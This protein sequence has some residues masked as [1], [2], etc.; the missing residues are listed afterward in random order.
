MGDDKNNERRSEMKMT[1][2]EKERAVRKRLGLTVKECA[3]AH[4]MLI[5]LGIV[6]MKMRFAK[7]RVL[8]PPLIHITRR[9]VSYLRQALGYDLVY[10]PKLDCPHVIVGGRMRQWVYPKVTGD[11]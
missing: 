3:D 1:E 6:D 10:A 9:T 8:M 11:L 2:G 7:G 4:V 5:M